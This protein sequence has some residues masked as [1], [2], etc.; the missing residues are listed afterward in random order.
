ML[1]LTENCIDATVFLNL[2]WCI[3]N[4]SVTPNN[5][6]LANVKESSKD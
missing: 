3:D 4:T 1:E 6:S 5:D 2:L